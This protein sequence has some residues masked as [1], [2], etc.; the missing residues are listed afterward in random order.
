M[1][2]IYRICDTCVEYPGTVTIQR[3]EPSDAP[4]LADAKHPTELLIVDLMESSRVRITVEG[5]GN[6]AESLAKH[7]FG[8]LTA[9]Y[10]YSVSMDDPD[11]SK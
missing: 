6:A 8:I 3:L 9:R 1:S 7:L 4:S 10:G 11:N 5:T 2:E